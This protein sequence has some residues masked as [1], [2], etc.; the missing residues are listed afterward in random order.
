MSVRMSERL[1]SR[2][3]TSPTP[4]P[5]ISS[6]FFFLGRG[7]EVSSCLIRQIVKQAH[8]LRITQLEDMNNQSNKKKINPRVAEQQQAQCPT[9]SLKLVYLY[10]YIC[11]EM[12][13]QSL[14]GACMKRYCDLVRVTRLLTIHFD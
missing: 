5:I 2:H 6:L 7:S 12:F 14:Q 4:G 11:I 10:I 13:S 9:D 1:T 3:P 8:L